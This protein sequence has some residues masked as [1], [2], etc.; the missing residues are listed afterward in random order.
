MATKE[1]QPVNEEAEPGAH[2]LATAK[3]GEDAAA[4]LVKFTNSFNHGFS[5][6][7]GP[8]ARLTILCSCTS[9]LLNDLGTAVNEHSKEISL[10]E[11][12][13]RVLCDKI[14]GYFMKVE[15]ALKLASEEKP[16]MQGRMSNILVI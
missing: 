5:D 13:A 2:I 4:S 10:P 6:F 8:L 11:N 16:E 7:E 15:E 1:I 12:V 14:V 3:K 9:S